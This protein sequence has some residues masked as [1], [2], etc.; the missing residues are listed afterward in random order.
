[1]RKILFVLILISLTSCGLNPQFT[2][3]NDFF[4]LFNKDRYYTNG[5][6]FTTSTFNENDRINVG[7][8]QDIYTPGKKQLTTPQY[9]DRPY[10]GY[11]YAESSIERPDKDGVNIF[12]VQAGTVGPSA[13][14]E[15]VQNGFHKLINGVSAKGWNNQLHDEPTLN[16]AFDRI[17]GD[18]ANISGA[19]FKTFSFMGAHL[20]NV[21]TSVNLGGE[22]QALLWQ[23]ENYTLTFAASGNTSYVARDIFLD[24]NTFRD[25][26]SVSKDTVRANARI[27]FQAD[28]KKFFIRF[29]YV[30]ESPQFKQQQDGYH[31]GSLVIGYNSRMDFP[32]LGW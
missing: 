23:H 20:G 8:G 3:S 4:T 16:F 32:I 15:Q 19:R 12:G 28:Y 1:M 30:G 10:A 5:L 2:E 18:F 14:G 17:K 21:L 6:K 31:Y 22:A 25:S 13:M 27:G 24:G 7:V 9:D 26:L 29:V 11:L